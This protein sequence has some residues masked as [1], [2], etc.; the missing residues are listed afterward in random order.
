MQ[1]QPEFGWLGSV[2]HP[3]PRPT[4]DLLRFKNLGI[5]I[6]T[7]WLGYIPF[8]FLLVYIANS[9]RFHGLGYLATHTWL[10]IYIYILFLFL[11]LFFWGGGQLVENTEREI[12]FFICISWNGCGSGLEMVISHLLIDDTLQKRTFLPLSLF[13]F[14]FEIQLDK[15]SIFYSYATKDEKHF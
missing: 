4:P 12:S 6:L 10:Q 14:G 15:S 8:R 7:I 9:G 5:A 1:L 11:F 2:W 3:R 13:K